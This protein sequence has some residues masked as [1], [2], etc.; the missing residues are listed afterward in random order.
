MGLEISG[1]PRDI[2]ERRGYSMK[3][4]TFNKEILYGTP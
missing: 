2:K 3:D 1:N 4:L